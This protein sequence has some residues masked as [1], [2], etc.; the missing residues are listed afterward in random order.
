LKNLFRKGETMEH[1]IFVFDKAYRS[2]PVAIFCDCNLNQQV[3][4][5]KK[6]TYFPKITINVKTLKISLFDTNNITVGYYQLKETLEL[7]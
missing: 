7:A 5:H 1:E 2:G 4:P 3:G 6:G